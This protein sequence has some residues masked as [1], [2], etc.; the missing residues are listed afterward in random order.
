[1]SISVH[2]PAS[3]IKHFSTSAS[4]ALAR[5]WVCRCLMLS[6]ADPQPEKRN[7]HGNAKAWMRLLRGGAS[8]WRATALECNRSARITCIG[9]ASVSTRP[10]AHAVVRLEGAG[11]EER[12]TGCP[13]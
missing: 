6:Q 13:D 8:S 7:C 2:Q 3:Y 4:I 12:T 9:H 1:M 10:V 5:T 11:R